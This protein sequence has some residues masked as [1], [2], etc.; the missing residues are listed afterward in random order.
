MGSSRA[1]ATASGPPPAAAK[2]GEAATK[3]GVTRCKRLALSFRPLRQAQGKLREKS[4]SDPSHPLE[5]TGFARYLAFL[6]S[7]RDEISV[8]IFLPFV[9]FESFVV[10]YW[11]TS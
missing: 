6:A 10:I 7:W 9:R 1:E 3:S 4:F 5:V 8:E 11:V 2:R